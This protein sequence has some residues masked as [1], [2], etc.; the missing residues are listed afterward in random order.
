MILALGMFICCHLIDAAWG[1]I[2]GKSGREQITKNKNSIVLLVFSI[3][4]SLASNWA[5]IYFF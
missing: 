2:W 1:P 5:V 4:D 3:I